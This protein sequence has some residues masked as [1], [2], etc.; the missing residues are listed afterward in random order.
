MSKEGLRKAIACHTEEYLGRGGVIE[1]VPRV[2]Y[3][4]ASM[5]WARNRG[6]D[7]TPWQSRG[8]LGGV[9]AGGM[10]VFEVQHLEEGCYL[11]KAAAFEGSEE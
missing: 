1:Q 4:P 8:E 9:G 7:Y 10:N 5:P 3:C 2:I 11:T 6:W